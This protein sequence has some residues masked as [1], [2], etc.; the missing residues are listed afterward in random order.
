[1]SGRRPAVSVAILSFNQTQ[2]VTWALEAMDRQ[3]G[4]D[5]FEVIVSDDGSQ[6]IEQE[7]LQQAVAR[8]KKHV[9]LLLNP[10]TGSK[11]ACR[12]A[13]I[14]IARGEIIVLLD[15]DMVPELDLIKKHVRAHHCEGRRLV[16]GNRQWRNLDL[17]RG[18]GTTF[19]EVLASLRRP[20]TSVEVASRQTKEQTL[21]QSFVESQNA[22]RACFSCHLSFLRVP[23]ARF[24]EHFVGWGP[25]DR[26]FAYRLCLMQGFQPVYSSDIDAYHVE[27]VVGNI[28]RNPSPESIEAYL[29]NCCYL[30]DR[31]PSMEPQDVFRGVDRLLLNEETGLWTVAPSH[32]QDCNFN[33]RVEQVRGWLERRDRDI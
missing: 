15:G 12:N 10:H 21:R 26:E 2:T 9:T 1:M 22:W 8:S 17:L 6:P 5:E 33:H 32:D 18:A 24:D 13:A 3:V 28:F 25:E 23:E 29:R 7:I 30:Q 16:S 14:D 11:S 31:W 27:S 20:A 4:T 19:D